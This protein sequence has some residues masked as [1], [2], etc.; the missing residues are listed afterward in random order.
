M[1]VRLLG[2]AAGGGFPQ[3]NCRCL[4]CQHAR[5]GTASPR[6]QTSVA[7]SA[8]GKHWF[9]LNASPDVRAQIESF[10]PLLPSRCVRGTAIDGIFLTNADLDH[11]LGLPLLREGGRLI[12]HS[13]AVVRRTL[14]VRLRL[15]EILSRYGGITWREA[16]TELTALLTSDG[17]F[18]GI[19]YAA[20]PVPGKPPRYCE[21]LGEA[22]PM[23]NVGYRLEDDRTKGRLVFVPNSA[24]MT[25]PVLDQMRN[26]DVL[27]FD[28]TF[29]SERE[30]PA[31]G[32]GPVAAKEMGHIPIGGAEGSLGY[33]ANLHV[34][35]KVYI[36]VNNTNPVL[37]ED[38][39][40]RQQVEAAGVRVGYDG[41]QFIL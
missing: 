17:A 13:S 26:C 19:R 22:S 2:T 28:G 23:E 11:V 33:L 40:E 12:V 10:P 9:L 37:C 41:Q 39:T 6:M 36:H 20:F 4:N 5:A 31:L 25:E 34:P 18:S 24:V 15:E 8:D 7:V 35:L 16:P 38:S 27:L 29:W 3:W 32:L 14:T 30:M 1:H 21:G